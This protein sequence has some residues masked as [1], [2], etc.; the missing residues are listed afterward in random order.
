[1][2][3]QTDRAD[4]WLWWA[5]AGCLLIIVGAPALIS[6]R[7]APVRDLAIWGGLAAVLV[8]LGAAAVA[9]LVTRG[10]PLGARDPSYEARSPYLRLAQRYG[11]VIATGLIAL[12]AAGLALGAYW[13][14]RPDPRPGY[15]DTP[16]EYVLGPM[17]LALFLLALGTYWLA[18]QLYWWRVVRRTSRAS[19]P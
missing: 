8:G 2:T 1:M 19:R 6:S 5:I 17:V 7:P 14:P 12:C 3:G 16:E 11:L 4:A 13:Y 9:I 10:R 15:S 18:V